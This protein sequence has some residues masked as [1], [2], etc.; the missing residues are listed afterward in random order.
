M[1]ND[2]LLL[3]FALM[4]LTAAAAAEELLPKPFGTGFPLLLAAVPFFRE[5]GGA[6]GGILFA[7]AAGAIEE[8]LSDLPCFSATVFF[9]LYSLS[10]RRFF[11]APFMAAL[12]YPVYQLWLWIWSPSLAGGIFTRLLLSP[13]TAFA[14]GLAM[15]GILEFFCRKAALDEPE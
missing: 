15:T 7:L 1:R 9:A 3:V 12:A 6:T 8:T 2:L 4:T 14:A 5:R 10:Q 11:F 13:F